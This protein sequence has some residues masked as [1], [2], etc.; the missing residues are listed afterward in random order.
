MDLQEKRKITVGMNLHIEPEEDDS[1]H[2]NYQFD[3]ARQREQIK[4][5]REYKSRRD[6]AQV[7]SSLDLIRK[8]AARPEGNE[9]NIMVPIKEAVKNSATIGEIFGT[10]KQVFGE[11]QSV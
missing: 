4:N 11:Q 5:L 7:A 6:L 10:L 2:A 8:T 3:L 1:E 9:N